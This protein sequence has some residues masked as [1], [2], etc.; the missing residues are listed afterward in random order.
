MSAY[1]GVYLSS[2]V[3]YTTISNNYFC[4]RFGMIHNLCDGSNS[5]NNFIHNSVYTTAS[6][7]FFANQCQDWW[8]IR[9]NILYSTGSSSSACI[10][11]DDFGGTDVYI[12]NGNMFYVPNG[13]LIAKSGSTTY[14]TLPL[15]QDAGADVSYIST[16]DP[17]SVTGLL[18]IL[19]MVKQ[20]PVQV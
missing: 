13:A 20:Y 5:F 9:N 18:V 8:D 17:N 19:I 7:L 12:T 11:I 14:S 3:E 6:C 2:G 4:T 16:N 15:W 10:N 1:A